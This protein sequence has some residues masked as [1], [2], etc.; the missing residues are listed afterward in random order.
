MEEI[1]CIGCGSIVQSDNPK[2]A[3]FVPSSKLNS[4]EEDVICR[5]CFRLKNYNEITP[6]E[7]TKDD[8]LKII[9]EIART[10]SLIVKIIDIFDIEG[11]LIPQIQKLTNYNDLVIVANKRDLLPK[12]VKDS[13]LIHHLKKI[14]ADN[15][16]KPLN[17]YLM[18]QK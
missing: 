15:G 13:K 12:T 4:E 5:R 8:Y 9:G 1:R 3:G 7:I 2:K 10:D 11:S 6:L 16:V 14:L 17:L 18:N